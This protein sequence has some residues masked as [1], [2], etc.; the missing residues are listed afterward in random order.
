[1]ADSIS[2][3]DKRT[4][5]LNNGSQKGS[6]GPF[7]S[8]LGYGLLINKLMNTLKGIKKLIIIPF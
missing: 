1:M 7:Y 8:N 5:A 6:L 2:L 3:N 4:V